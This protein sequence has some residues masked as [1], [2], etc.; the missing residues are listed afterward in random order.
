MKRLPEFMVFCRQFKHIFIDVNA[1]QSA[2]VCIW[3]QTNF[4]EQFVNWTKSSTIHDN[5]KKSL[6]VKLVGMTPTDKIA[7]IWVPEIPMKNKYFRIISLNPITFGIV[8]MYEYFFILYRKCNGKLKF[9]WA[10]NNFRGKSG[11]F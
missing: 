10:I 6:L 8:C 7:R 2:I 4:D 11:K 3:Y 9:V 1:L 5:K